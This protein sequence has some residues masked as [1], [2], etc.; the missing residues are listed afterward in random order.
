MHQWG[1]L[2]TF[3]PY[4]LHE[5]KVRPRPGADLF[6]CLPCLAGTGGNGRGSGVGEFVVGAPGNGEPVAHIADGANQVLVVGAEF[7]AQ[8]ADVDVHGAG[9]AVVVIAPDLVEQ[10]GPGEN[11]PRMLGQ[12]FQ[13]LEFLVG[14]VQGPAVDAG[15]VA[16]L[17][18]DDAGRLDLVVLTPPGAGDGQ[19]DPGLDLGG[20]GRVK[21]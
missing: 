19:A 15:G 2:D 11:A 13:Q 6:S 18:N 3:D 1:V 9:A 17:V 8:A 20:P 10:L 16:V 14:E 4:V 7:G 12:I 5:K 21:A